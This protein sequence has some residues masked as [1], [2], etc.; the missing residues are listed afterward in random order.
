MEKEN[1]YNTRSCLRKQKIVVE[2]KAEEKRTSPLQEVCLEAEKNDDETDKYP[3]QRTKRVSFHKTFIK[4]FRAAE[5]VTV[6]TKTYEDTFKS[7]SDSSSAQ[8]TRGSLSA[9]SMVSRLG[10]NTPYTNFPNSKFEDDECTNFLQ[11]TEF[12]QVVT[13]ERYVQY[14]NEARS[15][16]TSYDDEE[17]LF[18]L[19]R[20]INLVNKDGEA[21]A[22]NARDPKLRIGANNDSNTESTYHLCR[23]NANNP[24]EMLISCEND[25]ILSDAEEEESDSDIELTCTTKHAEY[26]CPDFQA[27]DLE[28]P[29]FSEFGLS[30]FKEV[31]LESSVHDTVELTEHIDGKFVVNNMILPREG[32]VQLIGDVNRNE[33][34]SNASELQSTKNVSKD[35]NSKSATNMELAS[36][37]GIDSHF[38]LANEN[39]FERTPRENKLDRGSNSSGIAMEPIQQ[40]TNKICAQMHRKEMEITKLSDC[41]MEFTNVVIQC[42]GNNSE[43]E[44][45]QAECVNQE[46]EIELT[47][48]IGYESSGEIETSEDGKQSQMQKS[49]LHFMEIT[50]CCCQ[51]IHCSSELEEQNC[52]QVSNTFKRKEIDSPNTELSGHNMEISNDVKRKRLCPLVE[53]SGEKMGYC[54]TEAEQLRTLDDGKKTKNNNIES[55]T[56]ESE[57]TTNFLQSVTDFNELIPSNN[58]L[59]SLEVCNSEVIR[60]AGEAI[61]LNTPHLMRETVNDLQISCESEQL[62]KNNSEKE[63]VGTIHCET[64]HNFTPEKVKFLKQ[65]DVETTFKSVNLIDKIDSDHGVV[66]VSETLKECS[67]RENSNVGA[68]DIVLEDIDINNDKI[69]EKKQSP[70]KFNVPKVKEIELVPVDEIERIEKEPFVGFRKET[71]QETSKFRFEQFDTEL[72]IS[73]ETQRREPLQRTL[74]DD[75][76]SSSEDLSIQPSASNS[77]MRESSSKTQINSSECN[78]QHVMPVNST[79]LDDSEQLHFL[80]L[81]NISSLAI[82]DDKGTSISDAKQN[83]TLDLL[84]KSDVIEPPI[85]ENWIVQDK[86]LQ[87]VRKNNLSVQHTIDPSVSVNRTMEDKLLPNQPVSVNRT[88]EDKLLPNVR[89]TNV[90]VQHINSE[91]KRSAF[92]NLSKTASNYDMY[93]ELMCSSKVRE[94]SRLDKDKIGVKYSELAPSEQITEMEKSA[95]D[96]SVNNV[97]Q[98]PCKLSVGGLKESTAEENSL[99]NKDI[100]RVE[101]TTAKNSIMRSPLF[102]SIVS[103]GDA[104]P[105][106]AMQLDSSTHNFGK[107]ETLSLKRHSDAEDSLQ[108]D[109]ER[110][111]KIQKYTDVDA[112]SFPSIPEELLLSNVENDSLSESHII[113]DIALADKS[114]R[115]MFS[116]ESSI[117]ASTEIAEELVDEDSLQRAVVYTGEVKSVLE[118]AHIETHVEILSNKL[119]LEENG[120]SVTD[121]TSRTDCDNI[122]NTSVEDQIKSLEISHGEWCIKEL[123]DTIW[124]F[125]F[126]YKSMELVV[127]LGTEEVSSIRDVTDVEFISYATKKKDPLVKFVHKVL[128]QDL[129][130]ESLNVK[131]KSTRDVIEVLDVVLSHVKRFKVFIRDFLELEALE[132]AK[133]H[134]NC[135]IF[136]VSK[137]EILSLFRVTV[138]LNNWDDIIPSD[139][140]IENLIGDISEEEVKQLVTGAVRGPGCLFHYVRIIKKYLQVLCEMCMSRFI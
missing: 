98:E 14:L 71:I 101:N 3:F 72:N 89:E 48:M 108:T 79:K 75:H 67:F 136:D 119:L 126:L 88:M 74:N 29:S 114:V 62:L 27:N 92:I 125:L 95:V 18:G 111:E 44:L 140:S 28:I 56:D 66:D 49:N 112:E 4:E 135:V 16:E 17:D 26:N 53:T 54:G 115:K 2:S 123:S 128:L 100:S 90:S 52:F 46:C 33:A 134:N 113:Q 137:M 36:N 132:L 81:E 78:N 24:S 121:N 99:N 91:S 61:V 41:E 117:N 83:E 133:I 20:N 139:V 13:A 32:F 25:A 80:D 1:G 6:W 73:T 118:T 76:V 10:M 86:V 43:R 39:V 40:T 57:N 103:A 85:S 19:P 12:S 59:N 37:L 70:E 110:R 94:T 60:S 106:N 107:S 11:E 21:V 84:K 22:W 31:E 129:E 68:S 7:S 120:N 34:E 97:L 122:M 51:V 124:S 50:G 38:L 15:P 23:I 127:R 96:A 9:S 65:R 69:N 64:N 42:Q 55:C 30:Q 102:C 58:K 87:N 5:A 45:K 47:K 77:F 35:L 131:C 8:T 63:I 109:C 116:A 138:S 104:I 105:V 93:E 130:N 82:S